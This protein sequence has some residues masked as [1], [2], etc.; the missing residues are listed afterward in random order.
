MRFEDPRKPISIY[1]NVPGALSSVLRG[2]SRSLDAVRNGSKSKKKP[3][4]SS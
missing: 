1:F 3:P 4:T 2:A